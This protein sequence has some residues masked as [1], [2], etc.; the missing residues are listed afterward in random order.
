MHPSAIELA[1]LPLRGATQPLGL[2]WGFQTTSSLC[3]YELH[4]ACKNSTK[5]SCLKTHFMKYSILPFTVDV[6]HLKFG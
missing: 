6:L 3:D 1:R 4:N 2:R 5:M